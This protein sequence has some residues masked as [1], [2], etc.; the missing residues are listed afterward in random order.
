MPQSARLLIESVY[1][2]D[3]AISDGLAKAEQAQLAKYYCD[4]A[5]AHQMLLNFKPGYSPDS[6][7]FLAD[8]LSTRLAEESITLWLAK[9]VDGQLLPYACGAHPWEMSML[10]VRESWWR[11]HKAE[12][13]LLAEKPLQQWCVQQH[14]NPDFAVV[15]IVT[16]SPDCGY[17][18]SEGLIGTMEV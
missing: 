6:S 13:T 9:N 15:I 4:R 11:K 17:S 18:A 3:I 5:F 10:R 1:G 12:F 16:D 7:D 2:E 14:Q 8:K